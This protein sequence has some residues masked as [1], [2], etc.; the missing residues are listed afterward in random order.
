MPIDVPVPDGFYEVPQGDNK[1]EL[2]TAFDSQGER[3]AH[4]SLTIK[5]EKMDPGGVA[6]A[7]EG[8]GDR[9]GELVRIGDAECAK[10]RETKDVP[11]SPGFVETH[12]CEVSDG[13]AFFHFASHNSVESLTRP[14]VEG[15][16]AKVEGLSPPESPPS[17]LA[18]GSF[19][20]QTPAGFVQLDGSELSRPLRSV[21][22]GRLDAGAVLDVAG[23]R[24]GFLLLLS[25]PP[26][27]S[28]SDLA[29]EKLPVEFVVRERTLIGSGAGQC[30]TIRGDSTNTFPD[31]VF[32]IYACPTASGTVVINAD[33]RG[34]AARAV[35]GRVEQAI[36]EAEGVI[37]YTAP[38][39]DTSRNSSAWLSTLLT[40]PILAWVVIKKSRR[41]GTRKS[42]T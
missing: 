26:K 20:L 18:A 4:F 2:L 37:P 31:G 8:S 27:A 11:Y 3:K 5:H 38:P 42:G 23:E 19:R 10:I 33:V 35:L 14:A 9:S 12:I 15:A 13:T 41:G 22:Q 30:G 29:N 6:A 32:S 28:P 7:F 40:L 16:L 24:V 1:H 36:S 21:P 34:T 17:T 25:M 39:R